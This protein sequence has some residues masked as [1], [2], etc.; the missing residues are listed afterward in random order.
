MALPN[1]NISLATSGNANNTIRIGNGGGFLRPLPSLH[2]LN[3]V[4]CFAIYQ[5]LVFAATAVV[6]LPPL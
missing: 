2:Y 1:A 6:V 3:L 4:I 5:F